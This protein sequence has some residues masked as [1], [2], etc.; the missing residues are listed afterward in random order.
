MPDIILM[1]ESSNNE[2]EKLNIISTLGQLTTIILPFLY[3]L[4]KQYASAYFGELGCG[5]AINF[6]SFQET[7]SYSILMAMSVLLGM[8]ISLNLLLGGVPF[9]KIR[10]WIFYVMFGLAILFTAIHLLSDSNYS[11]SYSYEKD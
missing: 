5:W 1:N 6:L 3:L 4:G 2:L 8:I 9:N 11:Y 10:M 7:V